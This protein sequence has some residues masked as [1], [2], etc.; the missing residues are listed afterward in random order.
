MSDQP[1]STFRNW[2]GRAPAKLRGQLS[3]KDGTG[4][5]AGVSE[6]SEPEPASRRPMT[7][8]EVVKARLSKED[9]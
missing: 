8:A 1:V 6:K 7:A 3:L 4:P 5:D 2:F 9:R